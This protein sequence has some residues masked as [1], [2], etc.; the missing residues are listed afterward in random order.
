MA[1][2][3]G[4]NSWVTILEADAYLTDILYTQKWF[5][6]NNTELIEGVPSRTNTLVTAF[7]WLYNNPDYSIPITS[8]DVN[9]KNAQAEAALFLIKYYDDYDRR[10]MLISAGV[11]SFDRSKWS[12]SFSGV[13]SVPANIAGMLSNYGTANAIAKLRGEDYS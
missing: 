11:E 1:V 13:L 6:L 7:F 4:V 12:E 10:R 8:T 3:V 5:G 9:V 2:N